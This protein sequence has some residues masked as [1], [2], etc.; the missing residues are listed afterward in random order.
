MEANESI[1]RH[2]TGSQAYLIRWVDFY[3]C[4]LRISSI[5]ALE[6]NLEVI[7][8]NEGEVVAYRY[9]PPEDMKV[10]LKGEGEWLIAEQVELL[11]QL[12]RLQLQLFCNNNSLY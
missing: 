1:F 10:L 5:M 12:D 2:I 6:R 8:T 4:R 7:V 3:D 11:D 9:D